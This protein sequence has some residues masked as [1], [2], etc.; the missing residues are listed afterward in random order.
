MSVTVTQNTQT[1][2]IVDQQETVIVSPVAQS[3]TIST[4]GAQGVAGAAGAT[5]A[6]GAAG[7]AGVSH[8]TFIY[9]QNVPSSVWDITHNLAAYPSVSVLD[10][11]GGLV[12][13]EINYVSNN[14]II[15]TFS[16][17]FSGQALLN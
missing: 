16:G 6:T 17:S 9:N 4:V 10:S 7:A 1:V 2:E 3:V 8:A 11:T 13:G 15:M 12:F 5:G 14:R